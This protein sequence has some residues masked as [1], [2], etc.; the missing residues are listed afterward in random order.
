MAVRVH[1]LNKHRFE[2]RRQEQ[3]LA[4]R[5]QK[6]SATTLRSTLSVFNDFN[7]LEASGRNRPEEWKTI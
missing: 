6:E 3:L 4:R 5:H 2:P 7:R 1:A